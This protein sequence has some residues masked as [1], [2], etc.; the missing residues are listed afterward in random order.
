MEGINFIAKLNEYKTKTLSVVNFEEVG[1]DGPDHIKTFTIRAVVNGKNYPRGAGK[2][3]KEAKQNAARNALNGIEMARQN[4]P[5]KTP[6]LFE[7]SHPS[8]LTMAQPNFIC[9]LNEYS[10][11]EKV[12]IKAVESTQMGRIG[13]TQG[14]QYIV[15]V[16]EYPI[17]FGKTK[18]EAK[19]EA[20][21]IVHYEL[22]SV[23]ATGDVDESLNNTTDQQK[24]TFH[25]S[26]LDTGEKFENLDVGP[27][28]KPHS[29]VERNFIGLLN[30]YSQTTKY[31]LDFKC[32]DKRGPEH[33]PQFIHK[34]V[35]DN[36]EYPEGLG[37]TS[38][39]AKQNAAELAWS[40]LQEQ[41]DWN[42]QVS[43]KST[44]SDDEAS[45]SP[46]STWESLDI[47]PLRMMSTTSDSIQ[48]TDSSDPLKSPVLIPESTPK[49]IGTNSN[50]KTSNQSVISRFLAEFNSIERIGNGA[51]GRVYKAKRKLEQKY[52]AV[53]IVRSKEKATREV[54]AL[55]DLQHPNIVR[56]FTAWIED[57]EFKCESRAGSCSSSQSS[58]DSSAQYLYIQMELCDKVTLKV[59]ID[60]K[61]TIRHCPNRREESLRIVNGM[62]CGVEYIHS[63]KLIHRDLK[64]ANIMFGMDHQVKIGDFGLV[65][66]EDNGS[67][68]N[69]LER[70]KRT[71]TKS[72]MAPEQN[73][74]STYDRKVD[75][76]ALGL[77]YFE[78]LWKL[79]TGGERV[80]VWSDVRSVK[81]PK[82]FSTQFSV[83][84][85]LIASMLCEK[86]EDRPDA[87][88]VRMELK[89]FLVALC[90][91]NVQDNKTF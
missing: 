75:V 18:K 65:T 8:P 34:V 23:Q 68:E 39:E 89:K 45:S 81:F 44:M 12:T 24:N 4:D 88:S 50:V 9:W 21:K 14:C 58:S 48:F 51:F 59:W 54:L 41:S 13:A 11:R 55:A 46:L 85:K 43:C 37:K 7:G 71:G 26:I 1:T 30:Y 17:A 91:Q 90:E 22:Y 78:L 83:E 77:I 3:K 28:S 72:Y 15:G 52:F 66:A 36:K 16:K 31:V 84:H 38:K 82:G 64:P 6:N 73:N 5:I 35:I 76:F 70:T 67:D 87:T 80:E 40:A 49:T 2:T 20:A 10:Q 69:L 29:V 47:T 33:D 56:Y 57:S 61:N 53:K 86:P 32:I 74:Q 60:S 63:K 79:Y 19:E 27:I 42:S 25:Q 62:V